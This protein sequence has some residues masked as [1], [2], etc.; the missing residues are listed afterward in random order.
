VDQDTAAWADKVKRRI[1]DTA[2]DLG[3]P[4]FDSLF[5]HGRVNA[6]RAITGPLN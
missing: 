5:G 6:K 3:T 4:G 2:E 1:A